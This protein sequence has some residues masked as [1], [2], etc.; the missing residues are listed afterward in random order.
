MLDW[1]KVEKKNLNSKLSP[2]VREQLERMKEDEFKPGKFIE[3][4]VELKFYSSLGKKKW[5]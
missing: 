1:I 4:L 5:K 2:K 3:S